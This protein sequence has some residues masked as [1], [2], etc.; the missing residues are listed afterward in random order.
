MQKCP[1]RIN[2]RFAL[3]A[4]RVIHAVARAAGAPKAKAR[5]LCGIP[6]PDLRTLPDWEVNHEKMPGVP[7]NPFFS[8]RGCGTCHHRLAF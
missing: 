8:A 6:K 7:A 5:S 1:L 2:V 4:D 3:D